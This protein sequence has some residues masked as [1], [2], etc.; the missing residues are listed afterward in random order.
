MDVIFTTADGIIHT[1]P[2]TALHFPL[3][4]AIDVPTS[5]VP[6]VRLTRSPHSYHSSSAT[7]SDIHIVSSSR[8][9]EVHVQAQG[10]RS[11]S[12]GATFRGLPCV[13]PSPKC[14]N[15]APAPPSFCSTSGVLGGAV[16][17]FAARIPASQAY[18]DWC[19]LKVCFA[20][21]RGATGGLCTI[22]DIHLLPSNCTPSCGGDAVPG[23]GFG[24]GFGA[25]V[26]TSASAITLGEAT[27]HTHGDVCI[28]GSGGDTTIPAA[29][30]TAAGSVGGNVR[31]TGSAPVTM[32]MGETAAATDSGVAEEPH[33]ISCIGSKQ[34]P[35]PIGAGSGSGIGLSCSS[36]GLEFPS[37]SS[38][39]IAPPAF[40]AGTGSAPAAASATT[41]AASASVSAAA[42]E[43]VSVVAGGGRGRGH[44]AAVRA[45]AVPPAGS[46]MQQLRELLYRAAA[47]VPPPPPQ[48]TSVR[49]LQTDNDS[50]MTHPGTS[51]DTATATTAASSSLE[52]PLPS[53]VIPSL[54]PAVPSASKAN[55][56]F[57]A[58]LARSLLQAQGQTQ[59]L[60]RIPTHGSL[61]PSTGFGAP[62][63][64]LQQERQPPLPSAA[65]AMTAAPSPLPAIASS[66][67][68]PPFG[69]GLLSAPL[70]SAAAQLTDICERVRRIEEHFVARPMGQFKSIGT[71]HVT[72][73]GPDTR[74]AVQELRPPAQPGQQ[75]PTAGL[76]EEL[77]TLPSGPLPPGLPPLVSASV[78]E[79]LLSSLPAL[80]AGMARLEAAMV[81]QSAQ[82]GELGRQVAEMQRRLEVSLPPSARMPEVASTVDVEASTNVPT[83]AA[84]AAVAA[85]VTECQEA[86]T[87]NG[88]NGGSSMCL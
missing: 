24:A 31:L 60:T 23:A 57:A 39:L 30:E 32:A 14:E 10:D 18:P 13:P 6:S 61:G 59:P 17:A 8:I 66:F 29:G 77:L 11:L 47:S 64:Q 76:K 70:A 62:A 1:E 54:T 82:L 5:S 88:T 56:G 2:L 16:Q 69:F 87:N 50:N 38:S 15:N 21:A 63:P 40:V 44:H 43:C 45:G 80:T 26:P 27:H 53:D 81:Q 55:L 68:A 9:L 51:T 12:Y 4:V 86:T 36:T 72:G 19:V 33:V 20:S 79:Q 28:A 83:A 71:D 48:Q 3:Q 25:A 42:V 46:Q 7:I 78:V 75:E 73:A 22:Y 52:P 84:T 74:Q 37:S 34:V 65:P 41:A 35:N 67:P 58:A 49:R 85:A